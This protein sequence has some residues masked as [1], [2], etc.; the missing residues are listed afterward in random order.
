MARKLEPVT[1]LP[2]CRHVPPSRL[3]SV[4]GKGERDVLVVLRRKIA[5]Q[6]DKGDVPA[7]AL[8]ALIRQFRDLDKEIRALDLVAAQLAA[9]EADDD[10]ESVSTG[11]DDSAI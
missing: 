9:G 1:K 3:A 6:L 10:D 4:V 11:F 5:A 2:A 7:T 8:A